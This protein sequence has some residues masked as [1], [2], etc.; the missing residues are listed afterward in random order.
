MLRLTNM[1]RQW[2][3][4]SKILLW[5]FKAILDGQPLADYQPKFK[6]PDGTEGTDQVISIGRTRSR[7]ASK[8]ISRKFSGQY[9]V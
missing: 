4:M 5:F 2:R 9:G 3:M 6:H 1:E 7:V 8:Y